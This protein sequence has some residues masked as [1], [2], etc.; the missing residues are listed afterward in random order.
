[1]DVLV[2]GGSGF[3]GQ[4]L[5][6]VLDKRGHIVTAA[7]RSPTAVELPG[8]VKTA[9]INV[10]QSDVSAVVDGH[11]VVVNLVALPSHYQP[12]RQSHEEV[13]REGTRHLVEASEETSVERFVQMS[14]L[15]VDENS[16][17]AYFQAK[18]KAECIVREAAFDWVIYRPS[19]VFGDGCAFIPFIERIVPPLVAMLPGGGT[20]RL[21]P[22]W[23]EDLTPMLADGVDETCHTGAV[24]EIGGPEKLT[25]DET[26]TQICGSIATVSLPMSLAAVGFSIADCVP[27][28]PFGRDQYRVLKLDN[29]TA[30]NDITAFGVSPDD[31][32]TLD[33]YINNK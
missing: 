26:A 12:Q 19:V 22:I 33:K 11:D 15:G 2:V 31:L 3:I 16:H 21:Q 29:T 10:T 24:Y 9:V 8:S 13:H 20:M 28:V 23:V 6:R 17:T 4:S 5:C 32:R 27:G 18:R 25:L 30:E 1:M 7:S 14:G